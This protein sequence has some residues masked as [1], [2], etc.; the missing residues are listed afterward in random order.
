MSPPVFDGSNA[1]SPTGSS[2]P[3]RA[4]RPESDA[5][6]GFDGE[7]F[8]ALAEL[9]AAN[10]DGVKHAPNRD[11]LRGWT[12]AERVAFLRRAQQEGQR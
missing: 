12:E 8:G 11:G 7:Q 10:G 6:E 2:P 9:D 4:D 5:P 1:A 3:A